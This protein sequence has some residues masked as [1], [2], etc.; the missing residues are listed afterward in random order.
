MQVVEDESELLLDPR[1]ALRRLAALAP[2]NISDP[3][4]AS[5]YLTAYLD[6]KPKGSDPQRR[7]ARRQFDDAAGALYDQFARHTPAA[8]SLAVDIERVG[9]Y[10]DGERIDR[11]L[12]E[13]P[14]P[15]AAQGIVIVAR[16]AAGVFAPLPLGVPV[17]TR[18]EVGPIPKLFELARI[19]EDYEPYGVLVADQQAATLT[20]VGQRR[21]QREISVQGANY[22]FRRIAGG[23]QRR[24]QARAG[25]R[26]DQFA[27][28]VADG[29]RQ[30]LEARDVP[31]LIIAGDEVITS[32][33]SQFL[34]ETITDRVIATTRLDITASTNDLIEV[35]WPIAREAE[36]Q[37]E[38]GVVQHLQQTLAANGQAVAGAEPVLEALQARRVQQIVMVDDF[39]AEGWT[40]YQARVVGTGPMPAEHPTGGSTGAMTPMT[41]QEELV[42]RAVLS[43]ADIEIVQSFDTEVAPELTHGEGV[44]P[45][46]EAARIL[47]ELGGV[48]ALLRY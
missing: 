40:D 18:I 16:A 35:T 47:D 41:L 26:L 42:R 11:Q 19:G 46:T 30:E 38:L 25:E 45:R 5:Q 6:W 20:F 37:R 4:E 3:A 29:V 22:P 8:E 36:R 31:V 32:P 28:S 23:N 15:S 7:P 43:D 12:G 1:E 33:L 39:S 24:Y 48:G 21:S 10:L 2:A 13:I 34:H 44:I 17:E 27:R 9:R 14:L